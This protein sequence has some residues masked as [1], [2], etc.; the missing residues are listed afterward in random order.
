MNKKNCIT[1]KIVNKQQKNYTN[2]KLKDM[3]KMLNIMA[4][5]YTFVGIVYLAIAVLIAYNIVH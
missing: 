4:E 1:I 2:L 3:D 5:N